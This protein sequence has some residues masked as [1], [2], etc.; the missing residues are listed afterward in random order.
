MFGGLSCPQSDST[1]TFH[2]GSTCTDISTCHTFFWDAGSVPNSAR[3]GNWN[4]ITANQRNG[5][6]QLAGAVSHRKF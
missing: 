1:Q 5:E 3:V 6:G 2:M 4:N